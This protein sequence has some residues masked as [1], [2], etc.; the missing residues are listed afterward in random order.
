MIMKPFGLIVASC[1]GTIISASSDS[2]SPSS[3]ASSSH[4]E[5]INV[6]AAGATSSSSGNGGSYVSLCEGVKC[7]ILEKVSSQVS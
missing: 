6:P 3:S 4:L 2:S 1:L 7:E 5:S